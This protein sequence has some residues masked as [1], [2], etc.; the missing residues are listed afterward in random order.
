MLQQLEDS[1]LRDSD[2]LPLKGDEEGSGP[3][4]VPAKIREIITKHLSTEDLRYLPLTMAAPTIDS[5]KDENRMLQVSNHSNLPL[6][7]VTCHSPWPP[8]TIVTCHSP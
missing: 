7:I 3:T 5:V 1:V 4:K 2:G 6:T 8:L